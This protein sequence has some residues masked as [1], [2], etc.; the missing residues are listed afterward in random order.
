M[1]S[2]ENS[3]RD[4]ELTADEIAALKALRAIIQQRV[5]REK[6][7]IE[8]I[9][10]DY[11]LDIRGDMLRAML[12]MAIDHQIQTLGEENAEKFIRIVFLHRQR[13]HQTPEARCKP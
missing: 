9:L 5:D 2:D 10:D 6:T 4:I 13:Q 1:T 11:D 3:S 8:K 12:D 7:D